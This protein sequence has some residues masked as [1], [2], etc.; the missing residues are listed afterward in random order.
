MMNEKISGGGTPTVPSRGRVDL[1]DIFE[2]S[3]ISEILSDDN[4]FVLEVHENSAIYFPGESIYDDENL[5]I[6]RGENNIPHWELD[7]T[8]YHVCFR[9][10]D[11]VPVQKQ[12]EWLQER[13]SLM[14]IVIREKREL[15]EDEKKKLQYLYLVKIES[16][17]NSGYGECLLRIP[18]VAQIVKD[19]LVFYNDR[20]YILHSWC[21][22][23][24]HLHVAFQLL[25]HYGLSEV[26][27]GWKSFTA[28]SIN[29]ILGRQGTLWQHD[30]YNHIIRSE[31][32]YYRQIRYIWNNPD[33]AEFKNW[34]WR[35]MME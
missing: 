35:W 22:M 18:Q 17:L 12:Q 19:S 13:E 11:S 5:R 6:G 32:E 33:K 9:L 1:V 26:L 23:P 24:N 3:D 21:I 29:K 10:N 8:I 4:D 2:Y 14:G 15:T 34:Q 27:H 28:H 31:N 20:K 7:S 16:F 25:E 30:C